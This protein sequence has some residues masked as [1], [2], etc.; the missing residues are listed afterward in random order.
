M[1]TGTAASR[2]QDNS[3]LG[4][5]AGLVAVVAAGYVCNLAGFSQPGG[6]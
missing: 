2:L 5:G 4:I 3:L 6:N 1:T